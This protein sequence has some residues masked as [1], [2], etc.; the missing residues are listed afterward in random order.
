MKLILD[1]YMKIA[2]WW[3][4]SIMF[5]NTEQMLLRISPRG[6]GETVRQSIHGGGNKQD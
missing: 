1:D 6:A 5:M 4:H 3:K 2:I